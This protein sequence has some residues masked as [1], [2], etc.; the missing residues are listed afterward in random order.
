M[1]WSEYNVRLIISNFRDH[2][3]FAVMILPLTT[4]GLL[5]SKLMP[6]LL[7][8]YEQAKHCVAI[9]PTHNKKPVIMDLIAD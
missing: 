3:L 9:N 6:C 5:K 7:F 2:N 1:L 8:K 4:H